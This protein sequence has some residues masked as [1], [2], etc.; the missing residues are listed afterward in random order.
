MNK[1]HEKIMSFV[2]RVGVA[3]VFT[4]PSVMAVYEPNSWL[5]YFPSFLKDNIPHTPLSLGFAG[6]ELV[7]ATWI[8]YGKRIFIPSVLTSLLLL[9]IILFNLDKFNFLFR[10]I[11][12]LS[13]TLA[14][15]IH[16]Y[17]A[18]HIYG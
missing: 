17:S 4:Y 8:V 2:L 15:A 6:I 14:L 5:V 18:K 3:F 1:N 7:L 9:F 10:N 11:A 12:I 16:S 13:A